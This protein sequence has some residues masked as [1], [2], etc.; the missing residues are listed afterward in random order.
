MVFSCSDKKTYTM[1]DGLK[2]VSNM[3]NKDCPITIDQY[4]TLK[5]TGTY[6][7]DDEN[8]MIYTYNFDSQFF[9][10]YNILENDWKIDLEEKLRNS[11][12]TDPSMD[13]FRK[14]NVIT[15]WKY[16][17]LDNKFIHEIRYSSKDCNK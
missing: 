17:D 2:K 4:T 6:N 14:N 5:V 3:V 10:D 16:F 11:F 13:F 1:S 9:I 8:H 12:C 15:R 7:I